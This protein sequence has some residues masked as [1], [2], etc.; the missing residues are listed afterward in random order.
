[1]VWS[2]KPTDDD[3]DP[4]QRIAT[5]ING[6]AETHR[7]LFSVF[8]RRENDQQIESKAMYEAVKATVVPI[9]GYAVVFLFEWGYC[10][11]FNVPPQLISID[12]GTG[13]FATACI[14]ALSIVYYPFI[15]GVFSFSRM[16]DDEFAMMR[17]PLFFLG[18]ATVIVGS[19]CNVEILMVF[20]FASIWIIVSLVE[21]HRKAPPSDRAASV[22]RSQEIMSPV[23]ILSDWIGKRGLITLFIATSLGMAD[24]SLGSYVAQIPSD[25]FMLKNSVIIHIYGDRMVT[26][27]VT[28]LT[29]FHGITT[30]YASGDL[31]IVKIDKEPL[32]LKRVPTL[33]ISPMEKRGAVAQFILRQHL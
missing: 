24:F 20:T 22:A 8:A 28:S 23:T 1:M 30:A 7:N 27:P 3:Y 17:F 13:L 31:E 29:F 18:V 33:L 5:S 4:F 19:F 10:S 2:N 12:L 6:T 9:I 16:S 11:Y 25:H 15:A 21:R 26:A 14:A 32:I